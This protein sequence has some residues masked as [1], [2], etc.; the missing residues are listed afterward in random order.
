SVTAPCRWPKLA[1]LRGR[2]VVVATG[3]TLCQK[4]NVGDYGGAA[5]RSRAVFMAPNV[6]GGC[7]FASYTAKPDVVFFNM[8][9]GNL[10]QAKPIH[11][12]GL[13]SRAYQGGLQGGFDAAPD[14]DRAKS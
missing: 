3:G 13:V 11:A 6:D 8:D 14:F 4:S 9:D 12:A 1:D 5:P 2:V 10:P 7:P